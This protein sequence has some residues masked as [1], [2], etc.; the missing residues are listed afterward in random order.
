[1]RYILLIILSLPILGYG[2]ASMAKSEKDQ[3]LFSGKSILH[4]I[5][6]ADLNAIINDVGDYPSE[7]KAIMFLNTTDS[8]HIQLKTRGDFRKKKTHCAFPLLRINFKKKEV[9]NTVFDGQDKLKMVTHCLTNAESS[10]LVVKE[11]LAYQMYS[12]LTPYHYKVRMASVSWVDSSRPSDTLRYPAFLIESEESMENR[13][14]GK[15]IA[16]H[17]INPQ[18]TEP[19]TMLL[20]AIFQYMIGNTDWSIK[21]LHNIDLLATSGKPPISIP[22][23]FDFSGLVNAPYASPAPGLLIDS[24]RMRHYNGHCKAPELVDNVIGLLVAK[25]DE[26]HTLIAQ[27]PL[28]SDEAKRDCVSYI[29]TFF[30]LVSRG[31]AREIFLTKCRND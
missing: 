18:F 1:M 24:V 3:S 20:M 8:M 9:P 25:K 19:E 10:D 5:I 6:R 2:Q 31:E 21:A 28:L 22:Y 11:Y 17:N 23:D 13:C 30:Q 4:L 12:L 15:R 16:V 26:F 29:D 14:N 27:C 7:H